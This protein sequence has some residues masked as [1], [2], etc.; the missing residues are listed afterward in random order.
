[1][2]WFKNLWEQ[3]SGRSAYSAPAPDAMLDETLLP[4]LSAKLARIKEFFGASS[5]LVIHEVQVCGINC[6]VLICE[7]LVNTTTFAEMLAEPLTALRLDDPTPAALH[8]WVKTK[9]LM[10]PDQKEIT[11]YKELFRF[12]MSGFAVLLIDQ[13]APCAVFGLQGF[14]GRSVGEPEGERNVRGS[15]EGFNE[16]LRPNLGMLRRRFKTPDFIF[17]MFEIGEKS[18]TDGVMIYN[19]A[20]VAPELVAEVRRRIAD[21]KI[22]VV[23]ETGYIQPFLDGK[24]LSL[25]SGVGVTERPD[26]VCAKVAEGRVCIMLE[27]TPYALIVPYLFSE[28]FQS[29]DDYSH[30]PYFAT[31]TRLLKY[32]AFGLSVLLPGLYVA[33]GSFH[34]ELLP[35]LL[36]SKLMASE[37]STPFPLVIEALMIFFLYEVMR[38]AGLRMPKSV[39]HA[40]SIVGA[41]VIGDAAVTAGIVGAPMVLIVALTAISSFVVPSLYEPVVFLRF[42]F[43]LLGGLFGVFGVALGLCVM[44]VNLC[45]I[46]PLGVPV[47]SASTPFSLYGMRD[48]LLRV[49]WRTLAKEDLR[50]GQMPGSSLQSNPT[51]EDKA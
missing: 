49:G 24:P 28:N 38:E 25:F 6:A 30:R 33:L 31:F 11:T 32:L 10:A 44:L 22:D 14:A 26:T 5:D 13:I 27:G 20:A 43:I 8:D 9:S 36:L 47:T 3:N 15:R 42:A 40:V 34:P 23:L 45:A 37:Q 1:M 21:I 2:N 12:L 7:G 41:L 51:K 39:G 19:R 46:N 50:I 29:A 17:E 16:M 48:V 35:G 18:R 4:P